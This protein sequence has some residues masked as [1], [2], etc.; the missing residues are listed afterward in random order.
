MNMLILEQKTY[1]TNLS[2]VKAIYHKIEYCLLDWCGNL[3]RRF[4]ISRVV[5][6]LLSWKNIRKS[7]LRQGTWR[8]RSS[9]RESLPSPTKSLSS[10]RLR[11]SSMA[12]AQRTD[13][14]PMH[15]VHLQ[16]RKGEDHVTKGEINLGWR[17]K[18]RRHSK[19]IMRGAT[20]LTELIADRAAGNATSNFSL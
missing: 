13:F 7:M 10:H 18:F 14:L 4:E 20:W 6:H 12:F 15:P 19:N 11:R 17:L 8:H 5:N 9:F 2:L 16:R 1:W 3:T